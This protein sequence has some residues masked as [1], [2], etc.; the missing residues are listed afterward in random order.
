[1][2]STVIALQ[3]IFIMLIFGSNALSFTNTKLIN[4]RMES[5]EACVRLRNKA[6]SLKLNC[7]NLKDNIHSEEVKIQETNHSGIKLLSSI[8]AETRKVNKSQEIKLRNLIK[9]LSNE[10]RLRKD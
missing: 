1:M 3:I 10:N 6:P 5:Y 2:K 4:E 9:R 7:E 8:A